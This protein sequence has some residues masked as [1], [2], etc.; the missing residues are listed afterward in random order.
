MRA[1][2]N[3]RTTRPRVPGQR[4]PV[5]GVA[6]VVSVQGSSTAL[7][8]GA[9]AAHDRGVPLELLL[10]HVAAQDKATCFAVMDQALLDTRKMFPGLEVRVHVGED[11]LSFWL[12]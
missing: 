2:R 9:R 12:R 4:S 5:G 11:D 1:S 6:A 7:L 3:E 8:H 10:P